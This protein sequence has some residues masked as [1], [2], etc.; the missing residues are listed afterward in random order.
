MYKNVGRYHSYLL[1]MWRCVWGCLVFF[2]RQGLKR[3]RDKHYAFS[4]ISSDS[5]TQ[6]ALDLASLATGLPHRCDVSSFRVTLDYNEIHGLLIKMHAGK[7]ALS[8]CYWHMLTDL[9]ICEF[10]WLHT[11]SVRWSF[12]DIWVTPK[13]D[14]VMWTQIIYSCWEKCQVK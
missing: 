2:A 5:T 10:C 12:A 3:R 14:N 13:S 8:S 11:K 9:I 4:P 1:T 7:G 6:I